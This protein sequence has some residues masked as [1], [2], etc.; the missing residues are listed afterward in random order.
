MICS[1]STWKTLSV[2]EI[3]PKIRNTVIAGEDVE[4]AGSPITRQTT[5]IGR[6]DSNSC[7]PIAMAGRPALRAAMPTP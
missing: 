6:H 1:R 4:T 2:I 3:I 5:M 7:W